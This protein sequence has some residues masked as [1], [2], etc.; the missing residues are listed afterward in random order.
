DFQ[1]IKKDSRV[2]IVF[3]INGFG[4]C[5]PC[6]TSLLQEQ[7][8]LQGIPTYNLDWNDI[9]RRQASNSDLNDSV[10]LK[11]MKEEVLPLIPANRPIILVGHSFGGDSAAKI[12]QKNTNRKFA[13]VATLDPVEL[14]GLRCRRTIT[15]NVLN[16]HNRWTGNSTLGIPVNASASGSLIYEGSS[17][18]ND[19]T[20]ATFARFWNGGAKKR[21]CPLLDFT[22]HGKYNVRLAH[23]QD[24]SS[25]SVFD[26]PIAQDEYLQREIFDK[27]MKIK[28]SPSAPP[29]SSA[30]TD[31]NVQ[32]D[33]MKY[34][35]VIISLILY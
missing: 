5:S 9:W 4:G 23:G 22:C 12:A 34:L 13:L 17:I 3:L 15:S 14:G 25:G 16:Y 33:Y 7:L 18:A 30:G 20:N 11:Q 19:Q 1:E 31:I 8:G 32:P 21:D 27:I 24:V 26:D 6:I 28:N 10:L 2:P 29:A 35:P